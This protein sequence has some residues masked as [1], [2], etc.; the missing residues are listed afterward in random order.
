MVAGVKMPGIR[1]EFK[2]KW[3]LG[4][5]SSPYGSCLLL[6]FENFAT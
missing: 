2:Y 6:N 3:I 4:R 1:R 5:F